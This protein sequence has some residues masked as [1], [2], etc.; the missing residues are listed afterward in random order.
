MAR[1]LR[2]IGVRFW[3]SALLV[4]ALAGAAWA[5][6]A[7]AAKPVI[8]EVTAI[9][10]GTK[11]IKLKTDDGAV[12]SIALTDATS[13]LRVP[14]GEK[15]LKNAAKIALADVAVG[16]RALARGAVDEPSKAV[17]ARSIIIMTKGDLAQKQAAER[18]DWQKRGTAGTVTAVDTA[19]KEITL[20]TRGRES[21]AIAVDA[22]AATFRRYA[23]DSIKF[24]DAKPSS[25]A[26]VQSG[27]TLRV[28]GDKN[29]EGSHVK[30][31]AIISGAFTTIAGTVESVDAASGEVRIVNLQ[32]K[33]PVVVRTTS[34]TMM[35]HLDAAMATVLAQR[36]RPAEP[37]TQPAPDAAPQ[38]APNGQ[39]ANG[40]PTGFRPNFRVAGTM[41]GGDLQQV[42]E[43]MPALA[44]ADL[45]KG[46]AVIVSCS[47][48]AAGAPVTA[49]AFVSGV[50]PFLAAAPRRDGQVNL[51]SWN[52]DLGGGPEQ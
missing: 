45:N 36:L 17:A 24:A 26:D 3:T 10:A 34:A 25:F 8:G 50:E 20:T 1:G 44:L 37:G 15:D 46:A 43:R 5:Q 13:F 49:F 27:D 12:Y 47:K 4:C 40:Q 28:L 7:P 22:S 30:A 52:L 2:H 51:G 23:A 33:Q 21:K 18:A 41:N 48:G 16:D 35:R 6:T 29:E 19:T 31:Q 32:T 38:G 39:P 11:Q 42:L 9:D 14:P